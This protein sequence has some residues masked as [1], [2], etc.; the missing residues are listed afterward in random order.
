MGFSG[1]SFGGMMSLYEGGAN[2]HIRAVIP[3]APATVMLPLGGVFPN[4]YPVPFM[5]H[6][7][8][9]DNT[10]DYEEEMLRFYQQASP[11]KYLAELRRAGHYTYSDICRLDLSTVAGEIGFDDGIDALDDGCHEDNIPYEDAHTM[12]RQFSIGFLN[13]YL[14]HS[15]DSA[16]FFSEQA[17]AEYGDELRF[18]SVVE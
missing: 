16:Q 11:P 14:R 9:L 1:H 10:V 12:I 7:G 5:M 2:P 18:E 13:Y 15:R 8:L 3:F 17:A 4:T 6:G